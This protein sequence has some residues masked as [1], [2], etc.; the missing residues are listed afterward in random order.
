[1][2]VRCE[3]RPGDV[4]TIVRAHGLHYAQEQGWDS[5]FEDYV[6]AGL[7]D[8]CT[9]QLAYAIGVAEPVSVYADCLGTSE[10]SSDRLTRIIRDT[11]P[12]KPAEIISY[13]D[14]KRPIYLETARHGHFG[15]TG[16]GFTW[17]KAQRVEELRSAARMRHAV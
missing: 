12:L 9:V 14:L 5:T 7:A 8:R 4:G 11:F 6:A 10:I 13:L 3:L 2:D 1:M 17:E 16:P 15:R